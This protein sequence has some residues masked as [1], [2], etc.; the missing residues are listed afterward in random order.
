MELD[1]PVRFT[2]FVKPACLQTEEKL[3][4]TKFIATGWG[5]V[6]FAGSNSDVLQK[7]DLDY[8]PDERC[9]EIFG[10]HRNLKDGVNFT[11]QMCAG[12]FEDGKDTCQVKEN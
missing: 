1:S 3:D 10:T 9:K 7:V 11:S 12:G 2:S 4:V 8:F 5:S 6:E